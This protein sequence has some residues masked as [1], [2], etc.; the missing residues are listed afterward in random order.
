MMAGV[1]A[2]EDTVLGNTVPAGTQ[3][4]FDKNGILLFIALPH[5]MKLQEVMCNGEGPGSWHTVLY[6]S[7]Q[8]KLA[9]PSED[10]DVQGIPCREATFF[11]EM[12]G[13]GAGLY[14]HPNGK[15][16][17]CKLSK[18]FIIEGRSFKRGEHPEFDE[19]GRLVKSK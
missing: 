2:Q 15:L 10:Q 8:L 16:R 3:L 18:D 12:F 1:L 14:F 11:T 9:W 4:N 17:R 13:G 7:G 19:Q 6:P 5:P